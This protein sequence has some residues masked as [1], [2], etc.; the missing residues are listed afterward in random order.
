MKRNTLLAL[1]FIVGSLLLGCEN[2]NELHTHTVDWTCTSP[3]GCERVDLVAKFDRAWIGGN[4]VYL[5]STSDVT[6]SNRATRV[7]SDSVPDECD[8]LH[9]LALLGTAFEPLAFC[10][11]S[12]GYRMELPIPNANPA[13]FSE[14]RLDIKSL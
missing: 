5:H 7:P 6:V 11:T 1:F 4:E 14:W 3:E 13:V 9:G 2:I 8:E 10:K 12:G